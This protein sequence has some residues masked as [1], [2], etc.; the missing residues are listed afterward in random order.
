MMPLLSISLP[1]QHCNSK[2]LYTTTSIRGLVS[3][4]F[5][6]PLAHIKEL[7]AATA[8]RKPTPPTP[9]YNKHSQQ[10]YFSITY[11]F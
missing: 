7:Q 1:L 3:T 6:S 5:T 11:S 8:G 2:K 4:H 9:S 10:Q